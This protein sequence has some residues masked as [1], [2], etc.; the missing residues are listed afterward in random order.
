MK[1]PRILR[2][3][4]AKSLY[5][6]VNFVQ[7]SPHRSI[8]MAFRYRYPKASFPTWAFQGD[9]V[10]E[11]TFSKGTKEHC[12]IFDSSG[13][14]LGTRTIISRNMLP[15]KIWAHLKEHFVKPDFLKIIQLSMPQGQF[16]ELDIYEGTHYIHLYYDGK[17]NLYDQGI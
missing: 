1:L 10:W 11:V 7:K 13:N 4:L 16:Y 2:I 3:A 8:L 14:W 12:A 17:G 5:L 15:T 6:L 9:G